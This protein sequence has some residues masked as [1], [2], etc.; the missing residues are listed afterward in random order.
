MCCTRFFILLFSSFRLG[1]CRGLL[2]G[3]S[4]YFVLLLDYSPYTGGGACRA[5]KKLKI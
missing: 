2:R 5:Y 3:W 1:F 4:G